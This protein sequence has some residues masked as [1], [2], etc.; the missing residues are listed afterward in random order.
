[1]SPTLRALT[2]LKAM[3]AWETGEAALAL[4]SALAA[5]H[6]VESRAQAIAQQAQAIGQAYGRAAQPGQRLQLAAVSALS[7]QASA[8]LEVQGQVAG[9]LREADEL[10]QRE[11]EVLAQHRSRDESLRKVLRKERQREEA[12]RAK[13]EFANLDELFLARRWTMEDGA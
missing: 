8:S 11:R 2:A 3:A 9:A 4:S 6:E 5:H 1:M 13:V 10:V 12:E 7:R